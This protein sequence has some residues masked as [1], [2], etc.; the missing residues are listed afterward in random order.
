MLGPKPAA[1]KLVGNSDNGPRT[2]LVV[3]VEGTTPGFAEAGIG[4]P[5]V[6]P[7]ELLDP[8]PEPEPA[9]LDGV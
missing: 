5:V 4:V 3:S 9:G 7:V 6:S 2:G 8:L 1:R